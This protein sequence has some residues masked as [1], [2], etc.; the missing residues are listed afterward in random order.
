MLKGSKLSEKIAPG[1]VEKITRL[2]NKYADR[3]ENN[4]LI[5]N[6]LFNSPSGASDFVSGNSTPGPSVWKNCKTNMTLKE[7]ENAE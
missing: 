5:E 7:M 4:V 6:I 1:M 3:I 2:R